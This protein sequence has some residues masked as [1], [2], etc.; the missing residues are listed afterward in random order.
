[1][2]CVP[3]AR[4]PVLDQALHAAQ[5]GRPHEDPGLGRPPRSP[6]PA[7][8]HVKGEHAAEAGHLAAADGVPGIVGQPRVVHGGDPG[9][10]LEERRHGPGVAAVPLHAAA[11]RAQA[12]QGQPG[13]EGEATAPRMCRT[14]KTCSWSASFLA[15]TS[16][17]PARRCGRRCTWWS[18]GAPGPRP[19]ERLGQSGGGEGVVHQDACPPRPGQCAGGGEIGDPHQRV[20][21]RL[22][23][24][25]ARLRPQRRA[26]GGQIVGGGE[27]RGQAPLGKEL[28][29]HDPHPVVGVLGQDHVRP[30]GESL[31]QR[32]P[33]R[34]AGGEGEG[35]LPTL[36]ARHRRL[37]ELLGGVRLP[38][39]VVRGEERIVRVAGERGGE[40][41]GRRHLPGLDLGR[42]GV[43]GQGVEAHHLPGAGCSRAFTS[44]GMA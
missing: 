40:A 8:S 19:A 6:P 15:K 32:H 10:R 13:V 36:Q 27:A 29:G 2:A 7:P 39:V 42:R 9:V 5:G 31:E 14:W 17:R 11:Q 16:T 43:D 23:P 35:G 37:Q 12:A 44:A 38:D 25:Q 3:L 28:P 1:V 24:E 21:R 41:D 20:A 26:Q 18:R 22:E 33:R 34:H 30:G 4:G